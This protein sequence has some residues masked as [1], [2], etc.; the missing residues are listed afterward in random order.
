MFLKFI[1]LFNFL[2]KDT[3][4]INETKDDDVKKIEKYK[5]LNNEKKFEN[6]KLNQKSFESKIF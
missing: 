5:L 6:Q 4:N 2:R 1:L 3:L